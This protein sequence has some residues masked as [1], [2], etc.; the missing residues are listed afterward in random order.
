MLP[1]QGS[2]QGDTGLV[3]DGGRA[4]SWKAEQEGLGRRKKGKACWYQFYCQLQPCQGVLGALPE[5]LQPG[6]GVL[7]RSVPQ[8]ARQRAQAHKVTALPLLLLQ[9]GHAKALHR[10]GQVT[11]G[12]QEHCCSWAPLQPGGWERLDHPLEN[13]WEQEVCSCSCVKGRLVPAQP[14]GKQT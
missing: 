8:P 3:W 11:W 2:I 10:G 5:A 14:S 1:C 9:R 7:V 12:K 4:S 6:Q 13:G